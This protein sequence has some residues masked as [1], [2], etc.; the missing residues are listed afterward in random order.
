MSHGLEHGL[1]TLIRYKIVGIGMSAFPPEEAPPLPQGDDLLVSS[2]DGEAIGD[3]IRPRLPFWKRI[4]GEGLVISVVLHGVLLV[5]FAVWVIATITDTAVTDPETFATGSGGGAKGEKARVFEHK[6][7][8]RNAQNLARNTSRITSKSATASVALPDLPT[9]ATPSLMAGLTGGGASKGFG[10]GSGGGIGAGKGI[11]VGSGKNFVGIF[12]GGFK[13]ANALE[14]TLYDL[15]FDPKG[16]ALINGRPERIAEMR[17]VFGKLD[18]DWTKAK[19]LLDKDY[20]QAEKKLYSGNILIHPLDAGEATKAFECEKEIQAP[21]WLAYYEGWFAVPES[22]DYRFQGFADDM[23]AVAVSGQSVLAAFWP[24]Q[25]SGGVISARSE[26]LPKG[27]Y[28]SSRPGDGWAFR[29]PKMLGHL[30]ARYKGNWISLRKGQAYFIQIAISES[31]GGIFSSE[32]LIEKKG[33]KYTKGKVDD[34]IPYF[35]LEPM[36]PEE[37]KLKMGWKMP[38]GWGYGPAEP[39][40]MDGATEGPSFG[41]EINNVTP[42]RGSR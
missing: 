13:R 36:T 32:L 21:G 25:G 27:A 17:K 14:G 41:A 4:G 3:N 20:R 9:T 37:I 18:D 2:T 39:W 31:H 30:G 40:H 33:V 24:G 34:I 1:T 8:P 35:M 19:A 26:W 12:G 10:G 29:A 5:V 11:G 15:K 23:M 7:Q 6:M 28:T 38:G 22:G 42:R 16:K